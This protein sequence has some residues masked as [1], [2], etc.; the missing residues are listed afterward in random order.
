MYL[1]LSLTDRC[2]MRCF[3][4]HP[5]DYSKLPRSEILSFE[6]LLSLVSIFTKF[7]LKKL[8]ITGG[9][10]L[11]RK[12]VD[13]FLEKLGEFDVELCLSTNGTLLKRY[14]KLIKDSGFARVNV[15]LDSLDRSKFSFIT[16]T[17]CMDKVLEGIEEAL[18]C[19]LEVKI[20]TVLMRGINEDELMDFASFSKNY[21]VR[22]R[23]IEFMPFLHTKESFKRYFVSYIEAINKVKERYGYRMVFAGEEGL[24]LIYR[25]DEM[26]VEIGFI[27]PVTRPFCKDC[28][29]LR[30]T[31]DGRLKACLHSDV[32]V[33]LKEA[34]RKGL[35]LSVEDLILRILKEKKSCVS[36]SWTAKESMLSIG[37]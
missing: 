16:G 36:P 34:L 2:N 20:N 35:N 22:V 9:E 12:D 17:D 31:S 18:K 4:C 5:K 1:R 13:K 6:E 30:L 27:S 10:P 32:E 11:L 7:G 19:G 23:F 3:Y 29:R 21:G 15:S 37:G 26:D 8:R 33:N 25:I 28:D 24:A 14:A